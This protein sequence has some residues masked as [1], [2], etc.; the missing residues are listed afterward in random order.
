[1]VDLDGNG[2]VTVENI[3]HWQR[4]VVGIKQVV[5]NNVALGV[6]PQIVAPDH[7]FTLLKVFPDGEGKEVLVDFAIQIELLDE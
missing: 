2:R 5:P 3:V 4:P 6:G 1:L 7:D